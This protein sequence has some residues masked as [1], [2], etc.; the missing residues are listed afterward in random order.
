MNWLLI[1][2]LAY[3]LFSIAN[4]MEKYL[5]KASIPNP[6]VFTFYV[7]IMAILVLVLVPFG[8]LKVPESPLIFQAL[9]AGVLRVLALFFFFLGL[10]NFEVSRITPAVGG[11]VPIF[12]Y[13]LT[14]I[15]LGRS[16]IENLQI[17]AFVLLIL[18]SILI[19]FEKK[20][21]ITL[22]SLQVSGLSA[23]LFSLSFVLSK[24]VYLQQPFLSGLIWIMIGQFLGAIFFIF[25]KEVREE[26]LKK[27]EIL[28]RKIATVFLS[29][30]AIGASGFVLQ[31]WAVALVPIGFLAFINA[32]E[33]TKYVFLLIFTILLSLKFPQVL[34]EEISKKI[35][36]QKIIAI[37]FITAGLAIIAL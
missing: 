4:L 7:G 25:S 27:K 8:F 13:V 5:L 15:F 36:I 2:I 21:T 14:N 9:I 23:F 32:L 34:K 16:E 18:G 29:N 35:L 22:K 12:T 30:Q 24:S 17:L 37:L 6:K 1:T 28:E 10:K 26:I 20:K 31:N 3:F 11:L 19:V 33:G